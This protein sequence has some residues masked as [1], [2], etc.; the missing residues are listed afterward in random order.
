MVVVV[1]EEF[2]KG[3]VA[4]CVG[5]VTWNVGSFAGS[6]AVGAAGIQYVLMIGIPLRL[7]GATSE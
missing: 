4:S 3:A 1:I 5:M 2:Q 7:I 6:D